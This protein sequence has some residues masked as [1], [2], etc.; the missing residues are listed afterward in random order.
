MKTNYQGKK[1]VG[2]TVTKASITGNNVSLEFADGTRFIYDAS[3]G[4][5]SR[6]SI[7]GEE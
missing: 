3:D 1:I 6:W 4:G 7:G 2:K 5:Y